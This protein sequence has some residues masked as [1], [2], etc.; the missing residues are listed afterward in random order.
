MEVA[1]D[2]VWGIERGVKMVKDPIQMPLEGA[3]Q[4]KEVTLSYMAV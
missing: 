3:A 4:L 1:D 2:P